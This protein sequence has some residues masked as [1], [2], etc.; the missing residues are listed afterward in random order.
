MKF[1]YHSQLRVFTIVAEH[2]SITD[3]ARELNLT[4]GAVSQQMRQ[5]EDALGLT[6]FERLPRGI[7]LTPDGRELHHCSGQAY[8]SIEDKIR[9]LQAT[10]SPVLTIGLTTYFASRWLSP[11]LMN[12]MQQHPDIRLRLQ[13]MIELTNF[14]KDGIDLAIRWGKGDWTDAQSSLLFRCP[15]WPCGNK[16][17]YQ[18]VQKHGLEPV[19][20]STALLHDTEHSSAWPEWFS[21]AGIAYHKP[22]NNLIIPDPNV[23]VQ[24]VIDGQGIALN[25]A[26]VQHELR[27][28]KLF[29]IAGVK[30]EEYGYYLASRKYSNTSPE[31]DALIRWLKSA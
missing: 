3:A 23:R 7:A 19:L 11:R 29:Q 27:E 24:A 20:K 17:V 12:F 2:G 22:A 31:A 30:L 18:A 6:L 14:E 4:K 5:L 15:A 9:S 16:S 21:T 13:P 8:R 26:L 10:E 28:G 25:D 1:G